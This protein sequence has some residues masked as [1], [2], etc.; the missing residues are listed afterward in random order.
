VVGAPTGLPFGF[1][2]KPKPG[3]EGMTTSKASSAAPPK[4]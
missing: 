3:S 4:L 2:E 1:D